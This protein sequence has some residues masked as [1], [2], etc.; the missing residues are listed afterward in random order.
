[1]PGM[2]KQLLSLADSFRT[3]RGL[4]AGN[5]VHSGLVERFL[6]CRNGVPLELVRVTG[7]TKVEC[8]GCR[9]SKGDLSDAVVVADT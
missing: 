9:T 8:S 4:I 5:H 6:L 2:G 3:C 7:S 1:M